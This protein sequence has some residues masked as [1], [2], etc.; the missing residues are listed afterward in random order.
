M[1]SKSPLVTHFG[2]QSQQ[3]FCLLSDCKTVQ[4]ILLNENDNWCCY[5]WQEIFKSENHI[6]LGHQTGSRVST[7][8]N[9]LLLGKSY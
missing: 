5:V 3:S 6:I 8:K 1:H 9:N 2:I 4:T 7:T